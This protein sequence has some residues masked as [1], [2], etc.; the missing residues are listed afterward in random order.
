MWNFISFLLKADSNMNNGQKETKIKNVKF[1]MG[2][3]LKKRNSADKI[4]KIIF[5][6]IWINIK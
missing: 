6:N 5:L 3:Q 4:D 1:I 2:G